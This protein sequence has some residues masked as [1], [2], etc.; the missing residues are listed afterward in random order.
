MNHEETLQA[1][2]DGDFR[3]AIP[4]LEKVIRET[5]YSSD[6]VN[7]A[8]TL[9]LYR[10]GEQHRLA[11]AAFEIGDFLVETNPALA[12][13]YFQRAFLG[14]LDAA[15]VRHIGEI[16]ERWAVPKPQRS[17]SG[18]IRPVKKVAHV[19]GCLL[20]DHWPSRH[21]GMLVNSLRQQGVDSHVFTT[22]W[23]AA[24]FFN[25]PGATQSRPPAV[26]SDAVVASVE[27]N[28]D[29]RAERIASAIRA[30]G[31]STVFYH[32]N[33][34]E[35]I[36]ARVAALRPA[37]I[38][39]NVAHSAEMDPALFDGYIHLTKHGLAST[40]H[41]AEIVEWI[42]PASDIAERVQACAP[43]M[44]QAMGLESAETISA[45]L[46]D[47]RNVS[48]PGYLQSL[49]RILRLFP[50]HFHLFAGAGDVKAIRAFLH[51][52][53]V[54]PRVRFLGS[55]SDVASVMAVMDVYL[56]P[57]SNSGDSSLLEVMGAGRPLV[58]FENSKQASRDSIAELV[59]MPELVARN[60]M[61]YGQIAQRLLRDPEERARCSA[62]VLS[63]FEAEFGAA[64]LGKRY[65]QFL[66]RILSQ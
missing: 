24:W 16:F 43:N 35:Q 10:A 51:A 18:P 54:L 6:S 1:L 52:E 30:S 48:D 13:D 5:G 37:A 15:C 66:D 55:M 60:E 49:T 59:G 25:P 32:A 26:L 33:L 11:D 56:A 42:P 28:F 47:L 4:L 50:K 14:G 20:E 38:Q 46:A 7:H 65:L 41:P 27:G 17:D 63:R 9:A 22:E 3:M 12:M 23:A 58:V 2:K 57:F 29:E 64:L 44:R 40:R 62:A 36:T 45:T 8:Y 53:G 31:A 19:V 34:G 39:V 21:L 61:E